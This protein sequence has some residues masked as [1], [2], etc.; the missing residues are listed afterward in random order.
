[1]QHSVNDHN[2]HPDTD[3]PEKPERPDLVNWDKDFVDLKWKKPKDG[4]AP[5]TGYIIEARD[6]DDRASG[7][8]KCLSTPVSYT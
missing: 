2:C 1:M 5:I 8:Q 6:K 7:W 4:G 3:P